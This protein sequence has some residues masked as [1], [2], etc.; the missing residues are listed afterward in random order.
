MSSSNG[1]RRP[2]I[3]MILTDD[4]AAHSISAYGSV[5]NRTPRIDQIAQEGWLFENCLVTN[6]LCSPSRASILTGTY[7][8]INGVSTLWTPID[9]SQP[10]FITQL[11]DAGYKTAMI[12]KWHMGHGE[13]H[14]P[15]GFDYWDVVIEQG[16][17]WNPRFLS[18]DGVRNVQGYATDI[19]TDLATNWVESLRG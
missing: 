11:R 8:H 9:A 2:N 18:E 17:Y 7:S 16:E 6:S 5:V 4:H 15:E 14:N 13:G 3:V 19:I 10:T 1:H 12:G